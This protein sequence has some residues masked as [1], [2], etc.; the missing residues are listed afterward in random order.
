MPAAISKPKMI[1]G[2]NPARTALAGKSSVCRIGS[3]LLALLEPVG[4]TVEVDFDNPDVELDDGLGEGVGACFVSLSMAHRPD[5]QSYPNGQHNPFPHCFRATVR[6][7]RS[8]VL[9]DDSGCF[10]GS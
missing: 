10:A 9:R 6:L 4:D 5:W 3:I 8:W 7:E 2:K 1:P